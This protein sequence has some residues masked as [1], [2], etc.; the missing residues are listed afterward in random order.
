MWEKAC[1]N[2]RKF[3]WKEQWLWPSGRQ[4]NS[5]N[6]KDFGGRKYLSSNLLLPHTGWMTL[7][8]FSILCKPWLLLLWN[9]ANDISIWCCE[10][11]VSSCMHAMLLAQWLSHGKGSMKAPWQLSRGRQEGRLAERKERSVLVSVAQGPNQRML[12]FMAAFPRG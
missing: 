3:R 4:H 10:D 7:A 8:G 12:K 9:G 5:V 2:K 6:S 1:T 11:Y